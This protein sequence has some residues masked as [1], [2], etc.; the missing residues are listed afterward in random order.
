MK[1]KLKYLISSPIVAIMGYFFLIYVP[2]LYP[3]YFFPFKKVYGFWTH[4]IICCCILLIII[5]SRI[6]SEFPRMKLKK[7]E[8]LPIKI[9]VIRKKWYIIGKTFVVVS[10]LMNLLIVINAYL[11]YDGNISVSKNSLKD[12]GGINIISQ[13]Y[14]FFIIPYI[15]YSY[16]NKRRRYWFLILV[17]GG[18]IFIRSY[19]LAERLALL[20]FILPILIV[21]ITIKNKKVLITKFVKYFMIFIA[22]FML[23]ELT[24]QFKNQ[25]GNKNMDIGFKVSWT[26]ERFFDYYGDTQNKFYFVLDNNLSFETMNYLYWSE[27]ILYR[28]MGPG[29]ELK[30]KDIDFGDYRWRDFTNKGGL[31]N[32]Y[33]DFGFAIGI[34]F[35]LVFFTSFFKLWFKLKKGSLY[36]W[37]V[38]PVCFIWVVEFARYN[39][40]FLT[41]FLFPLITFSIIYLIFKNVRR[42]KE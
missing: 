23:L 11:A 24:R 30:N 32:A 1:I 28:I 34:V 38:Y 4:T 15:I 35:L 21:F 29:Y 39:G 37:S 10:I 36:A 25:Y 7:I 17:L 20:E 13:F 2:Y 19:L 41:R 26:L 33:T 14:L 12:F 31:T 40:V 42:I 5:F 6:L 22:F 18:L 8:S 27:R 3:T 9:P 16:Q